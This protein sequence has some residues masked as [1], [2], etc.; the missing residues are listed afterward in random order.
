M[1]TKK[2]KGFTL[3]ELLI[4][5][6]IIGIIAAIAIP[7]LLDAMNR[8]R[9]KA[10]AGDIRTIGTGVESYKIDNFG[11]AVNRGGPEDVGAAGGLN[12]FLAGMDYLDNPPT[13]DGW[14]MPIMYANRD[15]NPALYAMGSGGSDGPADGGMA[16]V[17][18][19]TTGD[20]TTVPDNYA[21]RTSRRWECDICFADGQF[22]FGTCNA[23]SDT[24]G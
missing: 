24:A 14:G 5:V 6:A 10:T 15:T 9:H 23:D 18:D 22:F 17:G 21:D 12:S 1:R 13:V 3:V 4:V 2:S 19:L 8:S 16:T 7:N 20:L 11:V